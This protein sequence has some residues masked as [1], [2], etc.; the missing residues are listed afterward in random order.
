[1]IVSLPM[2]QSKQQL[3][4]CEKKRKALKVKHNVKAI[5]FSLPLADKMR[6]VR[7]CELGNDPRVFSVAG[8]S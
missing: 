8:T 4:S 2:V 1:M 3:T 6:L 7:E 5:A